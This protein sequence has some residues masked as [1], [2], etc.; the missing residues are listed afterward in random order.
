VSEFH[1]FIFE[2]LP[3]RGMIVRL[4]DAWAEVLKRRAV[5]E[6]GP[7]PRA[8]QQ[9]LGEMTAAAVLMQGNI[10]FNGALIMQIQGDGPVKLAVA[11][12]H[13]DL[14]LRATV[15]L[16]G[17]VPEG[18]HLAELVNRQ[19][20]GRCAITLDPL[21]RQPGQQPYQGV[22]PLT[23]DHEQ[24]LHKLSEV[25]ELYMRQSEQLETKLVLACNEQLAAGLL[26]QRLPIQGAGNL[27]GLPPSK[28]AEIEQLEEDYNRIATLAASLKTEEL[29]SLDVD[30]ILRRLFWEE[31][32]QR[33]EPELVPR[34]HCTCS[35]ERVSQ[36]IQSLGEDE[37]QDI[38]AEQGAITVDCDFCGSRYVFDSVQASQLFMEPG[39]LP[40]S[41]PS[42]Q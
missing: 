23:D 5:S 41:S 17:E 24:P 8:V 26:I 42:I 9:M 25:L 21:G 35:R 13:S 37:A 1:K 40:P 38:V 2:G 27:E 39:D 20:Q 36:M 33:F 16:R 29:L 11:E 18:A 6:T 3:V 32:V 4:D 28:R 10:Q 34:F 15:T 7:Y 14:R 22:V 19:G 30:T 12:V 31:K